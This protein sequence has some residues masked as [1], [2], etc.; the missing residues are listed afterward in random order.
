MQ[1]P[2]P[3][4]RRAFL[5]LTSLGAGGL[6]LAACAP[7]AT[8]APTSFPPATVAPCRRI[9][10]MSFLAM[11]SSTS[12]TSS[13]TL[14]SRVA[15]TAVAGRIFLVEAGCAQDDFFS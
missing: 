3:T 11:T 12:L 5:R 4:S 13:S 1:I 14:P 9:S 7:A 8:P 2:S 15:G 10:T 6:V